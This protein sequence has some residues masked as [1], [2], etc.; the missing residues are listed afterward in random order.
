MTDTSPD[1][2][3]Q[4]RDHRYAAWVEQTQQIAAYQSDARQRIEAAKLM[5]RRVNMERVFDQFTKEQEQELFDVLQPIV[6]AAPP[7]IPY[8]LPDNDAPRSATGE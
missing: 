3:Q 2:R 6:D 8:P 1:L 7:P 5:I 4:L